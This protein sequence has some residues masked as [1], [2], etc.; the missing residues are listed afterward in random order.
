[1]AIMYRPQVQKNF[2]EHLRL[3][4][5]CIAINRMKD[6]SYTIESLRNKVSK[7][8]VTIACLKATEHV[9]QNVNSDKILSDKVE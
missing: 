5:P 8:D 2:I 7:M 1:M 4:S 9:L 3:K 6:Q